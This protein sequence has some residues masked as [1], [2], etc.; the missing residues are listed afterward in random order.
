MRRLVDWVFWMMLGGGMVAGCGPA[1]VQQV[2]L[3]QL[4]DRAAADCKAANPAVKISRCEVALVCAKS[5]QEG[6]KAIQTAQ[7]ARAGAGATAGQEAVAAGSYAA[8]IATC[9]AGGWK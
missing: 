3:R 5:C 2:Q 7:E 4:A 9:K 6:V 1:L 8:A